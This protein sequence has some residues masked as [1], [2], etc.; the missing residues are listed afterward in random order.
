M[1]R[2]ILVDQWFLSDYHST[3]PPTHDIDALAEII[4][5]GVPTMGIGGVLCCQEL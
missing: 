1:R 2:S 3:T 4:H 5:N